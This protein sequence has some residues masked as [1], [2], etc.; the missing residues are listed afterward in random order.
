[1]YPRHMMPYYPLPSLESV[2]SYTVTMR[3]YEG[4]GFGIDM[5][6]C[7]YGRTHLFFRH[8]TERDIYWVTLE[9]STLP[10]HA[11]VTKILGRKRRSLLAKKRLRAA[12]PPL[13]GKKTYNYAASSRPPAHATGSV[14][15]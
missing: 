8:K 9:D 12:T 3:N 11:E 14:A 13:P 1:M 5:F 6:F 7:D 2:L 4:I 15:L 10:D